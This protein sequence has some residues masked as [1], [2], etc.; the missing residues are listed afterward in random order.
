MRK[1]RIAF[2][3][4]ACGYFQVSC[5]T[6][7]YLNSDAYIKILQAFRS[8]FRHKELD[9]EPIFLILS[10]EVDYKKWMKYRPSDYRSMHIDNELYC[11]YQRTFGTDIV[12]NHTFY[13][14]LPE[15]GELAINIITNQYKAFLVPGTWRVENLRVKMHQNSDG[16]P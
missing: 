15:F 13:G 2:L 12:V 6:I 3:I 16:K 11:K 1:R 9:L 5:R 10:V 7:E 8:V 4:S 14:R